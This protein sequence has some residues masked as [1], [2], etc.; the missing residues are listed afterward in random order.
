MI[1]SA[2]LSSSFLRARRVLP[3]AVAALLGAG[4]PLAWA[5][6]VTMLEQFASS[7]QS[8]QARFT[9]TVTAPAK[10]GQTARNKTSAG[11][12][13]FQRPGRFKFHYEKPFEQTIVADG[14]TLWLHDVDLNQVSS[15]K[16]ADALGSTPAALVS[17]SK[18]LDALRKD[19]TL[20]AEPT[21]DG[22]QWVQ[23]TPK[24][25][26]GQ[27]KSVRV[28]LRQTDKGIELTTL[29]ILDNFGQRSLIQ[30]LGFEANAKL[31]AAT[32]EFKPPAGADVVQQ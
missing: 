31:P 26:D 5:D 21:K 30:F 18:N 9:Q 12:F 6:S 29:D 23:A 4:A 11:T 13:A 10:A 24:G 15:R 1:H 22:I 7:V 32:F 16:Q 14:Q 20:K 2:M 25:S 17:S 19:F 27:L 8:G 3:L 28:G